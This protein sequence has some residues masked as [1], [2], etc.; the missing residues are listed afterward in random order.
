VVE[1]LDEGINMIW[2]VI[3]WTSTLVSFTGTYL[4]A[5]HVH[6]GW[7]F[8]VAADFGFVAFGIRKRLFGFTS[9]CLG[10]MVLNF[11]GWLQ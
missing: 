4:I 2:A 10:Y 6:C 8:G 1:A 11:Y 7:M 3:E 5:R 9:L